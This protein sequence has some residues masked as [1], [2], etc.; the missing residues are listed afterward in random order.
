[1]VT[2]ID[3]NNLAC[4]CWFAIEPL[5]TSTGQMTNVIYGFLKSLRLYVKRFK[6]SK[7]F[8]VWDGAGKKEAHK[9]YADYKSNRSKFPDEFFEQ[10]RE[11]QKIIK[12][13]S[14]PQYQIDNVEAD[15]VIGT[16]TK[17]ARKKG[18]KVIIISADHDFEQLISKHVNIIVPSLA[19]YKEKWKDYEFILEKYGDLKPKDL[20]DVMS[21]SGDGSDN[22]KGLKGVGEKTAISLIRANNGLLNLLN[23]ID[24]TKTYDRKGN[25]K[26]ATDKLKEQIKNN[27][28]LIKIFNQ[29][30][31]LDCTLNIVADFNYNRIIDVEKLQNV[32]EEL[33]FK[34]FLNDFESWIK[35]FSEI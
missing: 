29:I 25:L 11:L 8:I 19:M 23:D 26:N 10:I 32:F 7:F 5:T 6:G 28:E 27:V 2:I 4:R 20:I 21:L 31:K 3:G 15:D 9:L 24:N 17:K 34:S 12:L 35:I 16:I 13:L 14:I 1:M 18:H 33:E 22:V 30:V